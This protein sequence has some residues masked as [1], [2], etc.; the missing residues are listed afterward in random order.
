MWILIKT[1]V[2]FQ[3][4]LILG[5]NCDRSVLMQIIDVTIA[6]YREKEKDLTIEVKETE[7]DV[8]EVSMRGYVGETCPKYVFTLIYYDG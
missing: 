8:I 4:S 2:E 3:E 5:A 1:D 7:I 6:K